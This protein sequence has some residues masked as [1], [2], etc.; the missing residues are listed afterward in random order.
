[1]TKKAEL[2]SLD[3]PLRFI[4][5]HSALREGWDNPN[6]FQICTLNETRSA[7]RKRQE[8]GRG[9]R[10]PVNQHG[11]R[12]QDDEINI[13][14]V[15]ANESYEEFARKLQTEYEEDYGIRFGLVP[16]EAF[17]RLIRIVNN[18]EQFLGQDASAQ[19]WEHLRGKGYLDAEGKILD[20]FDPSNVH[21][22]LDVPPEYELLRPFIIDEMNKYIFTRRIINAR[23]KQEVTFNKQI[24]LNPDFEALWKRIGQRTRFRVEFSTAELISRAAERLKNMPEITPIRIETKKVQ[25]D[26]TRAGVKAETIVDDKTVTENIAPPVLPDLLAYLQNETELTRHTLVEIIRQSGR[27]DDFKINPQMFIT[28]VTKQISDNRY[29]GC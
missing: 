12:V 27:A 13:L 8:I 3:E 19:I 18:E 2:L 26:L 9:L 4:F 1:M 21:F 7:D 28:H 25:I 24:L 14:T 20:L 29:Q 5:S 10:L 15:V 23:N 16:K 22:K 11:E 6:V 17:S